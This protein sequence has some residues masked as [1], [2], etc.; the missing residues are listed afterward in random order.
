MRAAPKTNP[1]MINPKSSWQRY[2]KVKRRLNDFK[3]AGWCGGWG[4]KTPGY[5]LDATGEFRLD[6]T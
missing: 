6:K 2:T 1:S 3:H 5:P 4:S